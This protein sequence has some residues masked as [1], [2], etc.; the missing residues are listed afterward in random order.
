MTEYS[1]EE[2]RYRNKL[3]SEIETIMESLEGILKEPEKPHLRL[4]K[5]EGQ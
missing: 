2:A 3:I 1:A 4:V 5:D